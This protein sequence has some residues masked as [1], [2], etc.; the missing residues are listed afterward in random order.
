MPVYAFKEQTDVPHP[1]GGQ[2]QLTLVSAC[3]NQEPPGSLLCSFFP[4]TEKEEIK[5]MKFRVSLQR[6]GAGNF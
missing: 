3:T 2:S 6:D 5:S 4:I 1:S